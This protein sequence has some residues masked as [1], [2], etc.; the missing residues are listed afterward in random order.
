MYI[1]I[2]D[3]ICVRMDKHLQTVHH[4]KVGTVPYKV[5]LKEAKLYRGIMELDDHPHS[6]LAEEPSISSAGPQ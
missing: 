4:L 6:V 3:P 2:C 1:Y 5:H